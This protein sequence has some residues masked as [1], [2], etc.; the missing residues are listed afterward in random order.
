MRAVYQS[1]FA[2]ALMLGVSS[3]GVAPVFAQDKKEKAEKPKKEKKPKKGETPAADAKPTVSTEFSKALAPY[4]AAA[5]ASNWAVAKSAVAAAAAIAKTPYE[6]FIAGQYLTNV[7]VSAK[8]DPDVHTG[9]DQMIDSGFVP[10]EGLGQR[11][12][13]S[14]NEAYRQKNYPKAVS[15]LTLALKNGY[16]KDN[17]LLLLTFAHSDQNQ[18]D[19]AAAAVREFGPEMAKMNT[20]ATKQVY[21]RI[22]EN[23]RQADRPKETFEW[24][25]T[26]TKLGADATTWRKYLAILIQ[27]GNYERETD[28]DIRRLMDSSGAL[29]E[30]GDFLSYGIDAVEEGLPSEGLAIIERGV[31]AGKLS[32][33]VVPGKPNLAK[34]TADK[35]RSKIADESASLGAAERDS[36][37]SKT[38]RT[39]RFTA[40]VFYSRKDWPKAIA[41]YRTALAKGD[42][43][44]PDFANIV[45]TRL[46]AALYNSGD[47]AGA[48]TVFQSITGDRTELAK[49]WLSYIDNKENPPVVITPPAA[50]PA[51]AAAPPAKPK[52]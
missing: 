37:T 17:T 25:R 8:S 46:G 22:A 32:L 14:G 40:D 21:E 49:F 13:F 31:A 29:T 16:Y 24:L 36:A 47:M 52:N 42:A 1:V 11:A 23:Y 18:L 30:R 43:A 27:N 44:K 45:N 3:L 15:R 10:P 7:G 34:E 19:N 28:L 50:A 6:K 48:K 39:A 4:D 35:A 12:F 33:A 38:G 2:V 41:L 5:K 51:P 20:A 26:A 9:L